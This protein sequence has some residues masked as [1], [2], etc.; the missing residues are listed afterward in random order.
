V[1]GE[2]DAAPVSTVAAPYNVLCCLL[3]LGPHRRLAVGAAHGHA[4]HAL[5]VVVVVNVRLVVLLADAAAARARQP[6]VQDAFIVARARVDRG[7]RVGHQ[8]VAHVRESALHGGGGCAARGAQGPNS[9]AEFRAWPR[10]AGFLERN[11]ESA[12][13]PHHFQ[14]VLFLLRGVVARGVLWWFP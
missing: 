14:G 1:G 11:T 12:H 7:G 9:R 8:V 5:H 10:I 3:F 6:M 2:L 13:N 4:R